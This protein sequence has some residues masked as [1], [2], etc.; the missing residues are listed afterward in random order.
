[1]TPPAYTSLKPRMFDGLAGEIEVPQGSDVEL[2]AGYNLPVESASAALAGRDAE[3]LLPSPDRK[4]CRGRLAITNQAPIAVTAV[5]AWGEKAEATVAVKLL[6]DRPPEIQVLAPAGRAVSAAGGAPAIQFKVSDDYGSRQRPHREGRR[7]R[8]RG[9][10]GRNDPDLAG[11]RAQGASRILAGGGPGAEGGRI[12]R[13]P[14]GRHGHLPLRQSQRARRLSASK[15]S[16]RRRPRR[17]WRRAGEVG[18]A[19]GRIID[20]QG[21][22]RHSKAEG[23]PRRNA[24]GAVEGGGALRQRKFETSQAVC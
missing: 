11:G 6:P 15:P 13:L 22:R 14:R 21:T 18:S 7:A 16:G 20:G 4:A 23:H 24:A 9:P 8:T 1:M 5:N 17:A 2:A 3:P 19:V 10:V 12:A